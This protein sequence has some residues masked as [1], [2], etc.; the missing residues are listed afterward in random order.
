MPYTP[1][2]TFVF[3]AGNYSP[4]STFDFTYGLLNRGSISGVLTGVSGD[5]QAASSCAGT[6][7]G[8]LSGIS[9]EI[10]GQV[11]N[12]VVVQGSMAGQLDGVAGNIQALTIANTGVILGVLADIVGGLDGAFDVNVHRFE[13]VS[14]CCQTI[15]A[16]GMSATLKAAQDQSFLQRYSTCAIVEPAT[17]GAW[18]TAIQVDQML[19]ASMQADCPA[20]DATHVNHALMFPVEQMSLLV[21]NRCGT[22]ADAGGLSMSLRAEFDL[23]EFIYKESGHPSEDSGQHVH[24]FITYRRDDFPLPYRYVPSVQFAL[25]ADNYSPNYDFAWPFSAPIIELSESDIKGLV[26]WHTVCSRQIAAPFIMR[27]CAPAQDARRPPLGASPPIDPPP[28]PPPVDPNHETFV[29]PTQSAYLMQHVITTTLLDLTPINLASVSLSLDA[30]A[31][32]WS[33]RGALIN[34]AQLPLVKQVGSAPVHLIVTI[35][36]YQWQVLVE[37]I[38]HNRQF[39]QRSITLSGRGLTALLGQ[40]YEQPASATQGDLLTVQQLAELQLPTGWTLDWQTVNWNVPAG[41]Y[42]YTNQT[43]IQALTNLASDIGAMLVPSRNSQ[44]MTMLPRY[45]VLPWDFGVVPAD[46]EIPEAVLMNLVQRPVVP[47]QANGVYV[48]G[49]EVGG[50]IGWC[51]RTGTDGAKLAQTVSNAL[52]TDVIGLRAVGERVLAAQHE[53]PTIQSATLPLDGVDIPLIEVGQL[54]EITVDS[55]P[56]RGIVN[57]VTIDATLSSVRQSIQ[58]GEETPNTWALFKELLPRDPLLIATLSV[59]D[60]TTSLM[61]LLD[62]GVVRVRG[63]GTVGDKYYIRAGKIDGD[64]PA[65]TQSEIVI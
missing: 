56:V 60:G 4:P 57:G 36:G 55:V 34:A 62:N 58:L 16:K 43:P 14:A 18:E 65:M 28:P 44:A 48:H 22:M 20:E 38:E 51:R 45:P 39:G 26:R 15:G 52:M 47:S 29:I 27:R 10:S 3:S 30:D 35:N 8:T 11:D 49:G 31:F 64:A 41:A 1:T 54:V 9:G 25:T 17:P 61:T 19:V 42:S 63:T 46:V 21:I 53:Q 6:L 12:V 7:S 2:S 32:A 59:T 23:L 40:P 5:L 33:F 13:L 37:R 50:Q 24:R